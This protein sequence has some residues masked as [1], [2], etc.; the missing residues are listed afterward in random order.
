[1]LGW[2]KK[3]GFSID[4]KNNLIFG[5]NNPN[6]VPG[7]PDY[8]YEFWFKVDEN[9]KPEDDIRIVEFNG[10]NYAVAEC[11]GPLNLPQSWRALYRWCSE[12]NYKHGYHQPL[13]RIR[14]NITDIEKMK[15]ELYCPVEMV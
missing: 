5:F 1:M 14:E 13:E 11:T 12:N 6:P 8:G 9:E 4:D 10:G 2:C 3:R 7:K 15:I